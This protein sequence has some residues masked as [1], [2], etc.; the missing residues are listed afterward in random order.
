MSF[1]GRIRRFLLSRRVLVVIGLTIGLALLAVMQW[2][3]CTAME[4]LTGGTSSI[5]VRVVWPAS[6]PRWFRLRNDEAR[7]FVRAVK[8]LTTPAHFRD[9]LG[10]ANDP[11][12]DLTFYMLAQEGRVQRVVVSSTTGDI[13][14]KE[15]LMAMA[16]AG[17]AI[18]I[19]E[20]KSMISNEENAS[21]ESRRLR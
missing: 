2:S 10:P 9:I 20:T 14:H 18:S 3:R 7:R 17:E 11:V 4:K 16:M 19:E 8:C 12:N 6:T 15:Y 5:L 1:R 13:R 21:P